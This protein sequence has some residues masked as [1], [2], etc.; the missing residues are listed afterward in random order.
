MPTL[1]VKKWKTVDEL[2]IFDYIESQRQN[3][4]ITVWWRE[5]IYNIQYSFGSR[6]KEKS[7]TKPSYM[8]FTDLEMVRDRL[9]SLRQTNS[10]L[11][12]LFNSGIHIS[13]SGRPFFKR[14]SD[15]VICGLFLGIL[16]SYDFHY[17]LCHFFVLRTV[18]WSPYS[19][20][21]FADISFIS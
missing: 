17:A 4:H 3:K 18:M 12:I 15:Q 16:K 19:H 7:I 11:M 10:V 14:S 6:R 2:F 9:A 21:S 8:W 1:M 5:S 13:S 20:F